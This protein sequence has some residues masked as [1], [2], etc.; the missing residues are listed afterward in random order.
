M[1]LSLTIYQDGSAIFFYDDVSYCKFKA[2]DEPIY[3]Q[4]R[5]LP[6]VTTLV[7][8]TVNK[9]EKGAIFDGWSR[10]DKLFFLEYALNVQC[11][12]S[13]CFATAIRYVINSGVYDVDVYQLHYYVHS[14]LGSGYSLN[15]LSFNNPETITKKLDFITNYLNCVEFAFSTQ[16]L[17]TLPQLRVSLKYYKGI[18]EKYIGT[19]IL[20]KM[21]NIFDI[22]GNSLFFNCDK[23]PLIVLHSL[24]MNDEISE[25]DLAFY[26]PIPPQFYQS[27]LRGGVGD[28]ILAVKD[29]LFN[30]RQ[31]G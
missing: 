22:Y 14:S 19:D 26:S 18:P 21:L 2:E 12:N 24:L 25:S 16:S 3:R 17:A 5:S 8:P 7:S 28:E 9:V 11:P 20:F 29:Y 23:T 6:H 10:Q 1:S 4:L 15:F 27:I 31:C 30:A 13:D